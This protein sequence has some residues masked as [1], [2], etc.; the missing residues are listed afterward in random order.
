[1]PRRCASVRSSSRNSASVSGPPGC[2]LTSDSSCFSA[3]NEAALFTLAR[4]AGRGGT[5]AR[6]ERLDENEQVQGCVTR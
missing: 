1:M 2:P 6:T 5:G 4:A 3:T